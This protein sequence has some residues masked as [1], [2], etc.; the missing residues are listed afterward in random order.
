VEVAYTHVPNRIPLDRMNRSLAELK[1]KAAYFAR[2]SA[3]RAFK[4]V[5]GG[6][7]EL[8]NRI[9]WFDTKGEEPYPGSS[10]S[11]SNTK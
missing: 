7:D 4:D 10:G 6:E 1:G 9:L 8:M 3:T 2:L 5:D 11:G